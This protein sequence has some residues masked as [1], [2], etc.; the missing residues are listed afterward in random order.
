MLKDIIDKIVINDNKNNT[1]KFRTLIFGDLNFSLGIMK[2]KNI[3]GK[4]TNLL[5]HISK[6]SVYKNRICFLEIC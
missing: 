3:I 2:N 6:A 4:Y 1:R 5:I